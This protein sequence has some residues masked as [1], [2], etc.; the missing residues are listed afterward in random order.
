MMAS[1]AVPVMMT[2]RHRSRLC[3]QAGHSRPRSGQ[4]ASGCR[5]GDGALDRIAQVSADSLENSVGL[6][7]KADRKPVRNPLPDLTRVATAAQTAAVLSRP[8]PP[9]IFGRPGTRPFTLDPLPFKDQDVPLPKAYNAAY[10]H[11]LT[12]YTSPGVNPKAVEASGYLAHLEKLMEE[13]PK[14]ALGT[15]FHDAGFDD[16]QHSVYLVFTAKGNAEDGRPGNGIP[17]AMWSQ[18]ENPCNARLPSVHLVEKIMNTG[19]QEQAS[20][21]SPNVPSNVGPRFNQ[22][23]PLSV[24]YG[25]R[26][27]LLCSGIVSPMS[28]VR[29]NRQGEVYHGGHATQKHMVHLEEEGMG[30]RERAGKPAW[31]TEIC[32]AYEKTGHCQYDSGCK[33]A[34]GIHELQIT[35]HDLSVRGLASPAISPTQAGYFVED[36]MIRDGSSSTQAVSFAKA[37][38]ATSQLT[39]AQ[40]QW[41]ATLSGYDERWYRRMSVPVFSQVSANH[42]RHSEDVITPTPF[43]SLPA[44]DAI[45]SERAQYATYAS[46]QN[47]SETRPET[48]PRAEISPGREHDD[49]LFPSYHCS[50]V[51][52][53]K[54]E[55]P[56]FMD[57]FAR[58][59]VA[60]KAE[61]QTGLAFSMATHSPIV[62]NTYFSPSSVLYPVA[63]SPSEHS[64]TLEDNRLS[65]LSSLSDGSKDSPATPIEFSEEFNIRLGSTE[66]FSPASSMSSGLPLLSDGGNFKDKS[67]EPFSR[68][69]S[70]GNGCCTDEHFGIHMG[71]MIEDTRMGSMTL[72]FAGGDSIWR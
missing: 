6:A 2:R 72:D 14:A 55:R 40:M 41:Q 47:I 3:S 58:L 8:P 34:H 24:E 9:T 44:Q 66:S 60:Y 17:E 20:V 32:V 52:S 36:R 64:E 68:K 61:K 37:Q 7:F 45:G 39:R 54:Q 38:N 10:P 46:M 21:G 22:H 1:S 28:D 59:S 67:K 51:Q 50:S 30:E 53:T 11:P 13:D 48:Y 29:P 65:M 25:D 56:T 62:R 27:A 71:P 15:I 5:N 49:P 23:H 12:A 69:N 33:F 57:P 35:Q 31:K 43:H 70:S 18:F 16:L 63:S 4:G 42:R 26:T 19:Q